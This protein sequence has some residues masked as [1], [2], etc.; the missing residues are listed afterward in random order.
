MGILA[1]RINA[2]KM[3]KRAVQNIDVDKLNEQIEEVQRKLTAALK[4]GETHVPNIRKK[5]NRI[6]SDL[7]RLEYFYL[8]WLDKEQ[9][10]FDKKFFRVLNN[11]FK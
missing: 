10:K 3:P 1:R 5:I 9:D 8:C 7:H 4:A 2:Y 6:Y 11:L